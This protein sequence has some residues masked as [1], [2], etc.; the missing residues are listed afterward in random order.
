[1]AEAVAEP[2]VDAL[3]QDDAE[4]EEAEVEYKEQ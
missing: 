1:M 3:V 2:V 4:V